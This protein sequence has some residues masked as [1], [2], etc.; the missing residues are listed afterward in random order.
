MIVPFFIGVKTAVPYRIGLIYGFTPA[1]RIITSQFAVPQADI[2]HLIP[3]PVKYVILLR[4][5][6]TGHYK[7]KA[8]DG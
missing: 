4:T 7:S 1:V 2:S 3:S 6:D 5:G 8:V